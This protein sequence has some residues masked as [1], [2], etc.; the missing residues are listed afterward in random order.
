MNKY[1]PI[2]LTPI[3]QASKVEI[4]TPATVDRD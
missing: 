1:D 4:N 3:K 2:T